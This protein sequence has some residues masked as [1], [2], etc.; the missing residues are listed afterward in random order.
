MM[1]ATKQGFPC[2]YLCVPAGYTYDQIRKDPWFQEGYIPSDRCVRTTGAT[3]ADIDAVFAGGMVRL[4]GH[5][6]PKSKQGRDVLPAG[7]K[8]GF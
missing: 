3:R 2:A 5:F 6:H 8:E 7:A 4:S 1:E